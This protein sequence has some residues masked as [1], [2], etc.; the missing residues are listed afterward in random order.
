MH[1]LVTSNHKRQ[2]NKYYYKIARVQPHTRMP[3][4][5]PTMSLP[6]PV[7]TTKAA[8]A[9][10]EKSTVLVANNVDVAVIDTV[11]AVDTTS[12]PSRARTEGVRANGKA[13]SSAATNVKISLPSKPDSMICPTK[14][15]IKLVDPKS[16][17]DERRQRRMV[18]LKETVEHF[19]NKR[20]E[21]LDTAKSNLER[22]KGVKP[23]VDPQATT[24][25][26]KVLVAESDLLH[27][28]GNLT[29]QHGTTFA[30][31]N[32]ANE[33][34][35]GGGYVY[36]CAAQEE[37][38]ARR[39][40]LHYTFTSSVTRNYK[41]AVI[42]TDEMSALIGGEHG[43]VYLSSTP[44][45]CV[46]GK[47]VFDDKT[48]G[49]SFYPPNLIFPF[50]ELRS[51]AVNRASKKASKRKRDEN[52][53]D[54]SMEKRIEAQFAT[55]E[56]ANVRHVVLSAFGCGAFG[57]DPYKVASMYR[58]AVE[59]HKHNFD[60]IAF[61]IYYAGRG[62]SNYEVFARVFTDST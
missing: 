8:E 62:K 43:R 30:A 60:V 23:V 59:R 19:D 49:Y 44:L 12:V 3:T 31:I 55:L 54:A 15:V 1:W 13:S 35:P 11:D 2:N 39:T 34:C 50:F 53:D 38:M 45:V 26:C 37:N 6:A 57:N 9:T 14:P 16:E 33:H 20:Q 5:M 61:A 24:P 51:A 48:L 42:Y 21:L 52:T 36:G 32:M 7:V 22:W 58:A 47:E 18:V 29:A 46:R 10:F 41:G 27:L 40:D 56:E 25:G 28:V 17:H 4:T